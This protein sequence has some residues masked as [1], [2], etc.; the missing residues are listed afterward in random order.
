MIGS[1]RVATKP[2]AANS[3]SRWSANGLVAKTLAWAA[4]V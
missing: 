2:R 3:K 1:T 4:K